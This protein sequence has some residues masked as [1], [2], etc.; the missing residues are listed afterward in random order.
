VLRSLLLVGVVLVVVLSVALAW[1]LLRRVVPKRIDRRTPL[2]RALDLVRASL[3][4]ST[5]DRRRALDLLGRALGSDRTA[6]EALDLAWSRPDPDPPRV[7]GL[8]EHV[9][10]RP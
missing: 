10:Q 1:P 9:E 8:V 3:G 2:E 6:R 5:P 4:R 7:E